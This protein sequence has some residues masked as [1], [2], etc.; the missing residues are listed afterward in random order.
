[1]V[2]AASKVLAERA[3]RARSKISTKASKVSKQFHCRSNAQNLQNR[4]APERSRSQNSFLEA[5]ICRKLKS[6]QNFRSLRILGVEYAR[7]YRHSLAD[8]IFG[9]WGLKSPKPAPA[10]RAK[11]LKH[12]F[13][14]VCAFAHT[15]WE[16]E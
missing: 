11:P 1:M 10:A 15:L 7:A 8:T 4:L 14:L 12:D 6:P 16:L 5:Q 13:S 9:H 2:C 3:E